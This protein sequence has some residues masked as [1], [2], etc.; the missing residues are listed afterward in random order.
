MPLVIGGL[1]T[2]AIGIG[3]AVAGHAA[4]VGK[5]D[6]DASNFASNPNYDASRYQY[7]GTP[8]GAGDAANRYRGWADSAQSRLGAQADYGRAN[9]YAGLA[10]AR[11]QQ[12]QQARQWQVD[13][14]QLMYNRATGATPSIAGMQAQHDMGLVS[15]QAQMQAQQAQAAQMAGAASARGGA[16]LAIAQQNAANNIANAN[17]QIGTN[18]AY[19]LQNI[20]NQAQVNAAQERMQAE[21]AA[22]GANTAIRGGDQSSQQL[23]QGM[24]AQ[25]AQMAQ[26]QAALQQQQRGFNDQMSLGMTGYETGV[27][28]DQLTANLQQQGLIASSAAQQQQINSGISQANAGRDMDYFKM[29]LGA[30][31]GG[32][33][34][35]TSGMGG[36]GGGGGGF[37][38]PTSFSPTTGMASAGGVGNPNMAVA[39]A[40]LSDDRA[41]T[42][43]GGLL[44]DD[45]AKL[46]A[47]FSDGMNYAQQTVDRGEAAPIP[48]E[49]RTQRRDIQAF[50]RDDA[51]AMGEAM[52]RD[53]AADGVIDNGRLM[54]FANPAAGVGQ[55]AVG[56]AMRAVAQAGMRDAQG[57]VRSPQQVDQDYVRQPE[58]YGPP[59]AERLPAGLTEQGNALYTRGTD[60]T[61]A[62][63][64]A[65]LAPIAYEYKP[66]MGPPGVRAGVRAQGALTQPIT[67][68]MVSQRPDGLLQI[69]QDQ[70]LGTALAGVGHLAQKVAE[71]DRR[72]AEKKG[73]RR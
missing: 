2:G 58:V 8:N 13:T 17:G 4:R 43:Y 46:R 37:S 33:S 10:G 39:G 28:R 50:R 73:A 65:G 45:R 3:G 71:H 67:A 26:Y 48:A 38:P 42:I 23:A 9:D 25:Q 35:A 62:Q 11:D 7:G 52:R 1:V 70:G 30:V 20:S 36:G 69:D 14:G 54:Y 63:L 66:G 60:P 51:Q 56:G 57:P 47:A 64:G 16:G 29:G 6:Y 27:N 53:R 22:F 12:S 59:E 21:Q 55:A 24:S 32:A 44:S 5:S 41:K 61:T 34:M 19:A 68:P 72:L 31:Q 18:S 15:Q 49:Y 40:P